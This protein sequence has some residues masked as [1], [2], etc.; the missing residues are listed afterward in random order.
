MPQAIC[1]AVIV[2]MLVVNASAQTGREKTRIQLPAQEG[3][4]PLGK[5]EHLKNLTEKV[6]PQVKMSQTQ[7]VKV[8]KIF[9]DFL[10]KVESQQKSGVRITKELMDETIAVKDAQL[11][12]TLSADQIKDLV[13]AE[14]SVTVVR[15]HLQVQD[16]LRKRGPKVEAPARKSVNK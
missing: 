10:S 6:F 11:K 13:R 15:P 7:K 3:S 4:A 2:C 16:Q 12:A 14:R 8:A 1:F 9:D 5:K